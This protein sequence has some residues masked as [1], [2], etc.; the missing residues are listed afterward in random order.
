MDAMLHSTCPSIYG[1][2]KCSMRLVMLTT[3]NRYHHNERGGPAN[4]PGLNG[5]QGPNNG[6][7]DLGITALGISE[8]YVEEREIGNGRGSTVHE[9]E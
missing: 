3:D 2:R 1:W 8:M 9:D 6:D 4:G 5:A 7:C